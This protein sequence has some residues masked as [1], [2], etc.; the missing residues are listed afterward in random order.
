MGRTVNK[1]S[2]ARVRT[3]KPK[4]KRQ[5]LVLSDGGGLYLQCTLGEGDHVRRSWV[6]R[7]ERDGRRREAGL[8]P[9]YTVGLSE[10]R[11]RARAMRLQLLDG[12]DPLDAKHAERARRRLEAAKAMSFGQCVQAYLATHARSWSPKHYANWRMTLTDY[13]R[14][15]SD[16]PVADVD[17]DLVLKV[18]TPLW[19]TRTVT[20]KKLRGRIERV[21]AWAKGRGLRDGENPARW[22]GHLDEML[23]RPSKITSVEHFAAVPYTELPQIMCALREDA[24]LASLAL[25][26][27]ILCA[28]R[29]GETLH[30]T[31][32][33][34]DGKAWTIPATRRKV[35]Q[36]LRVPLSEPAVTVLE[37]IRKLSGHG[38][39]LF[40]AMPHDSM[41]RVL[42]KHAPTATVHGTSRAGFKTWCS[43]RTSYPHE[44]VEQ[45]LGHAI[46]SAIER[47][48]KRTDLFDRRVR[49]MRDWGA[50]CT[51]PPAAGATIT[52]LRRTP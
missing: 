34:F 28:T 18:L 1:L 23:A 24:T 20:A 17:T 50:F 4:R 49:L 22:S 31:W 43:E 10:A 5:A 52:L 25:Q 41:L 3:A 26:L 29:T 21:L 39:R 9:T 45:A 48:Y 12:I 8:G 19:G 46:P 32:D 15:I 6:F 14:P 47:A 11:E 2:P 40:S 38:Q 42:Q 44:V 13:C 33:E 35:R 51:S 30:A 36:E 7:F 27:T 16:L 37:Q